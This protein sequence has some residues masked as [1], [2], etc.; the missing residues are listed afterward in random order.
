[1]IVMGRRFKDVAYLAREHCRA[2]KG[3]ANKKN[4]SILLSYSGST[5]SRYAWSS[6]HHF[7]SLDHRLL[8]A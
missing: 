2:Q 6:L 7:E 5:A 1:M 4:G 3:A 8:Y